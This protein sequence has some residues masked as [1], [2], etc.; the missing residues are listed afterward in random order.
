MGNGTEKQSDAP[1]SLSA[2]NIDAPVAEEIENISGGV[3][4][5][6][7]VEQV[8]SAELP[9]GIEFYQ[10]NGGVLIAFLRNL[11]KVY[12]SQDGGPFVEQVVTPLSFGGK[13]RVKDPNKDSGIILTIQD[14][15]IRTREEVFERIATLQKIPSVIPILEKIQVEYAFQLSDGTPFVVTSDPNAGDFY[16][17][18]RVKIGDRY[19]QT[20]RAER[21]RD[22]GTTIIRTNEGK[23]K[24]KPYGESPTWNDE[25]LLK[26]E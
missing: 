2:E 7:E 23:F 3:Q 18:F 8:E 19:L 20:I 5:R 24:I 14:D 16:G 4:Q 15:S 9:E 22:G 11:N 25:P 12:I 17:S 10:S 1:D 6:V 26:V 13:I 21:F